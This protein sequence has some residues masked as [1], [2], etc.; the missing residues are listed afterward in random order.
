MS[1]RSRRAGRGISATELAAFCGVDLKTIHNWTNA[2][3]I[4]GWRTRGRHLRF[5]RLDVVDFLR[6]YGFALP[7]LITGGRPR[8]AILDT[9]PD[10]LTAA[11]KALG[12]RFEL[13]TFEV[14]V[15]GLVALATL[16]P[17]VVVLG[18]VSPLEV[19]DV[20]AR[21]GA[22]DATRGMRIVTV[23]ARAPGTAASVP[24][25]DP[26]KLREALERVTGIE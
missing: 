15:D 13:A 26:A 24:S 22:I 4:P 23:G 17:D 25:G 3:K 1:A 9:D 12:R 14:A 20:A 8:V 18:D 21:L 19:E 5:R 16:D 2:G 10:A 11:H 6:A 7:E